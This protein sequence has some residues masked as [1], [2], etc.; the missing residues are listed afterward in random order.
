MGPTPAPKGQQRVAGSEQGEPPVV[1]F[2]GQSPEGR[3][4]FLSPLQGS[5]HCCQNPGL[6]ALA[7]GYRLPPLQ[8]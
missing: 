3:Q 4:A 1:G 5:Y 7:L 6:A 2:R 8:G